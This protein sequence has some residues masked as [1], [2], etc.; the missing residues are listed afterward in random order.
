L[1]R[2]AYPSVT[3]G[4]GRAGQLRVGQGRAGGHRSD[5]MTFLRALLFLIGSLGDKSS[6]VAATARSGHRRPNN[7]SSGRRGVGSRCSFCETDQGP[8]RQVEGL[9]TLLMCAGCQAAPA[10]TTACHNPGRD[11]R[12]RP[13]PAG[14]SS[15]P[16]QLWFQW[17]CPL[18]SCDRWTILPSDLES[19]TLADHPGWVGRYELVR[20][21]P[22]QHQPGR[23]PTDHGAAG[24]LIPTPQSVRNS[25]VVCTRLGTRRPAA[26]G[27]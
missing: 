19:H 2:G 17:R 22:H 7:S 20:P 8:F 5:V 10:P 6:T 1:V 21:L 18:P 26:P 14:Q 13:T 12:A 23:V 27:P 9:F 11:A 15:S 24:K 3:A 4:Q 16:G 25:I